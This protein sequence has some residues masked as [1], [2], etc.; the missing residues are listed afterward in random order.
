MIEKIKAVKINEPID[1][2]TVLLGLI[3]VNFGPLNIFPQTN[4]PMSEAMQLKSNV[5]K[6][7]FDCKT[8]EKIKKIIQ[9]INT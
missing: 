7:N 8:F 5:N 9:K 6:I 3:E 1:P 4:P 2:I